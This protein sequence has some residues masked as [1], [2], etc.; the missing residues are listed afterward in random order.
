MSDF[1]KRDSEILPQIIHVL[2]TEPNIRRSF[3]YNYFFYN[4]NL[5]QGIKNNF[6]SQTKEVG[7]LEV[8]R[9]YSSN[10]VEVASKYIFL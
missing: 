8:C 7:R 4:Y 5:P 9:F 6:L 10:Q 3:C 1:I 2:N